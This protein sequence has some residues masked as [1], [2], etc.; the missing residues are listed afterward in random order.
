MKVALSKIKKNSQGKNSGGDVAQIQINDLEHKEEK[1]AFN[2]N[3]KMK[4][5][6]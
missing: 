5:E 6:F 1:K 2:K 3:S 4:K